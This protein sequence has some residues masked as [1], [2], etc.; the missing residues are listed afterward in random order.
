[1]TTVPNNFWKK[2]SQPGH[3]KTATGWNPLQTSRLQTYELPLTADMQTTKCAYRVT[4]SNHKALHESLIWLRNGNFKMLRRNS[5][6]LLISLCIMEGK[7]SQEQN[8]RR[9][10][11]SLAH[12]IN[13]FWSSQWFNFLS[14]ASENYLYLPKYFLSGHFKFYSINK[15]LTT[16][17]QKFNLYL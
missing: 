1:V 15:P 2:W 7:S 9:I 14:W 8:F 3:N 11:N 6:T 12:T 10:V 5:E 4:Q 17:Q 13:G 16:V